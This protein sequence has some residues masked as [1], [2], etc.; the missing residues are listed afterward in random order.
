MFIGT[1]GMSGASFVGA[2][3]FRAGRFQMSNVSTFRS[4][5]ASTLQPACAAINI[6]SLRD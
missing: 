5:G 2:K 6:S 3:C 1:S 4:Y